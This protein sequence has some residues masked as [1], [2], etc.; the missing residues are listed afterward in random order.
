MIPKS[1]PFCKRPVEVFVTFCDL[2][3]NGVTFPKGS[4]TEIQLLPQNGC[5]AIAILKFLGKGSLRGRT[6]FSKKVFP[7][8]TAVYLSLIF[9]DVLFRVRFKTNNQNRGIIKACS[10]NNKNVSYPKGKLPPWFS[11]F[12]RGVF[13]QKPDGKNLQSAILTG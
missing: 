2:S 12:F 4:A 5:T 6:L 7:S 10:V 11:M 8:N 1:L 3:G 13:L 9:I